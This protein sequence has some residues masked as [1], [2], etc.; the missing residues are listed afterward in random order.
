MNFLKKTALVILSIFFTFKSFGGEGG[1]SK[2]PR[3]KL[4]IGIMVDQMRWD[5]LYR[6]YERYGDEGFKRMLNEGFSCENTYINHL[7]TVTGIGHSTVYTGSV[8]AIHGITGNTISFNSTGETINCVGDETVESVGVASSNGKKSPVNLLANT[9]GDELKLA[10]NFRSKVIGIAI[11][12]RGA[13]LP[14]GHAGDA[15]WFDTKSGKWITSTY[16]KEK[17]P[18]WVEGFNKQNLAEKY[19]LGNWNTLYPIDTYIQSTAD[20]VSHEGTMEGQKSAVFPVATSKL[21]TKDNYDAIYATP[22]G[23]SITLD[24]AKSVIENENMGRNTETDLLAVSLS[25]T[26]KV[27]HTFGMNSIEIEDTYLRLDQAL[28]DFFKYLDLEVGEGNYTVFLTADHGSSHNPKFLSENKLPV[29]SNEPGLEKRINGLL[30]EKFKVKNLVLSTGSSQVRFNYKAINDNNLNE[31]E[32]RDL[33]VAYL[34]KEPNVLFVVDHNKVGDASVPKEIKE[35][36]VNGHHPDRSGGIYF[37]VNG[38]TGS[39]NFKGSAHSAWNPYDSKIPLIWMGW[40]IK[41]GQTVKQTHM[42]DVAPTLANLLR[43]QPPDGSIGKAISEV[44][45]D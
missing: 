24:F 39:L 1:Q 16:Y 41:K 35:R 15:Y 18:A 8:P 2:L 22:F 33:C 45:I 11:K 28:A 27:G 30:E 20:K 32:I 7:P 38:N 3:P 9:I 19:L 12:D 6:F 10:T 36:I 17:L 14:A 42:T 37:I 23:N 5:Y 34:R 43:I 40:G 26:D 21:F 31:E 13:I 4:V 25:S 29:Y 44:F